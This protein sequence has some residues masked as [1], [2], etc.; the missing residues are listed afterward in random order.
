M[1]PTPVRSLLA[2]LL[3]TCLVGA[4]TTTPPAPAPSPAS[5]ADS[6]GNDDASRAASSKS[7]PAPAPRPDKP[8][9]KVDKPEKPEKTDKPDKPAPKA[10]E[11]IVEEAPPEPPLVGPVWLSQCI[12]RQMEGGVI[13]CDADELLSP[14]SPRIKVYTREPAAAGRTRTGTIQLRNNLP[15]KYRFFVFP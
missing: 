4:C 13:R 5:G 3:T 6:N 7:K 15:R 2:A 11:V 12:N 8:P 14:P 10:P 9:V 1:T